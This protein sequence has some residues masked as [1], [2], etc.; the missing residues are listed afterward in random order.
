MMWARKGRIRHV[1]LTLMLLQ[2]AG[3]V[4]VMR[5]SRKQQA[6]EQPAESYNV[7][8]VVVLQ[9]LLKLVLCMFMIGLEQ[10][11]ASSAVSALYAT[12]RDLARIA[13]PAACFTLQN[14]VFYVALS[15]LHPLTFQISYQIK[16]LLTGALSVVMLGKSLSWP[17]WG[18]QLLLA[19]GIVLTQV[20]PATQL[21]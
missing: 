7:S 14:N 11:S 3:F 6:S 20:N 9:E 21:L 16:T 12:R 18:S 2:N 19:T 8:V 1:A 17:Q 15:N 4:L 5:Y 13:V 10:R